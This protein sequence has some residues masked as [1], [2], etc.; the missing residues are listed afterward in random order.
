MS[1][2]IKTGATTALE[3]A[4]LLGREFPLALLRASGVVESDVAALFDA[5]TL[6]AGSQ[7]AQ[8]RFASAA[9]PKQIAAAIP[10]S[11][12]RDHHLALG[13]A[14]KQ[15]RLPPEF[16]AAHFEAAHRFDLARTQWLKAGEA[17]CAT[18]NYRQALDH[19]DRCLSI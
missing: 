15:Q 1:R 17:A 12:A 3:R 19:I 5:G 14:A 7:P 10:W 16:V 11:R 18:G 8:A 2:R 6:V 4:A 13:E 9:G